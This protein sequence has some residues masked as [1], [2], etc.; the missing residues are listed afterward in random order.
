[1]NIL[2]IIIAILFFGVLI[3]VHELGHFSVAKW[4]NIRVDEFAIGMGPAILSRQKGETL[5]S[6]RAVPFG[7][8]CAMGE[9]DGDSDDPRA[10]VNQ[11]VWKRFLV[12]VAGSANNFILGFLIILILVSVWNAGGAPFGRIVAHSW[13]LTTDLC[14]LVWESLGMLVRGEAG[15]NDL[16]GP[17][18]IVNVMTDMATES[19][20]VLDAF[21][22]LAYFGAFVALN[23]AIMNMLPIPALDGGR[24]FFLLVTALIEKIS[25]KK[26]NPKYENYVHMAGMVLLLALMA[27][28]MF[29]D[30]INLVFAAKS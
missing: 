10:F 24:V 15:I 5:Y 29:H 4:C 16:T 14:K 22:N 8:Y 7:G 3:I 18:G 25:G 12:L 30:I 6:W 1:M 11:S 28:I 27:Y 2:Y 23:L 26:L 21:S 13:N 20:G 19:D 9:D 17:V